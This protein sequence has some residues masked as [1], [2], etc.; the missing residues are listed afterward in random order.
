MKFLVTYYTEEAV[1]D[2]YDCERVSQAL[3]VVEAKNRRHATG[4]A[5]D[6]I[7][8]V[9]A[10]SGDDDSVALVNNEDILFSVQSVPSFIKESEKAGRRLARDAKEIRAEADALTK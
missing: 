9:G 4:L 1:R 3:I 7:P 8:A 2:R 5:L 10:W 6:L